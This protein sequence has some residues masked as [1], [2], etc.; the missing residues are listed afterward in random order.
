MSFLDGD[1]L[2]EAVKWNPMSGADRGRAWWLAGHV[3]RLAD[4]HLM[5]YRLNQAITAPETPTNTPLSMELNTP[6]YTYSSPYDV[7]LLSKDGQ[8]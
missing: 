7:P 4:Q 3:A 5:N 1:A 2:Q 6:H 8:S